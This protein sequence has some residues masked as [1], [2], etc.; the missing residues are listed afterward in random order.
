MWILNDD[1]ISIVEKELPAGDSQEQKK[2]KK[3]KK[4]K[5]NKKKAQGGSR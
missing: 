4:S 5:K 3:S 1:V 2:H